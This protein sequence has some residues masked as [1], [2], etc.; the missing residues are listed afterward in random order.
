MRYLSNNSDYMCRSAQSYLVSNPG[1]LLK[2]LWLL[3]AGLILARVCIAD[4]SSSISWIKGPTRVSLGEYGQ[5]DVPDHFKFA[6]G[7]SVAS[8]LKIATRGRLLGVVMPVE[9]AFTPRIESGDW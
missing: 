9:T 5:L 3:L 7:P 1:K 6:S 8:A 2:K 4:S